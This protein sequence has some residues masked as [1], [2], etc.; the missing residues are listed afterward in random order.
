MSTFAKY[1]ATPS[2]GGGGS[3]DAFTII[4]TDQ[5]TY[6]TATGPNDA[7][8]LE[9]LSNTLVTVGN[10]G[11]DTVGLQVLGILAQTG[12]RAFINS[13]SGVTISGDTLTPRAPALAGWV[14]IYSTGRFRFLNPNVSTSAALLEVSNRIIFRFSQCFPDDNQYDIGFNGSG[15]ER[16]RNVYLGGT[17]KAP[18]LGVYA[19]NAAAITGG[20]AA[21]DFYRTSTGVVMV[22]Y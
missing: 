19:D 4:Q 2:G 18:N 13:D 12:T 14:D 16:P 10:S 22:V 3:G 20:L 21:G 6:P 9:G 5:G 8:T 15:L 11:T 7:L 17:V 1:P